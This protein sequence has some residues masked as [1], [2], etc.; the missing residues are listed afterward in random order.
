MESQPRD[1]SDEIFRGKRPIRGLPSMQQNPC[2]NEDNGAGACEDPSSD[3][4][5]EFEGEIHKSF[6]FGASE[7]SDSEGESGTLPEL[8]QEPEPDQVLSGTERTYLRLLNQGRRDPPIAD[9][10]EEEDRK[11]YPSFFRTFEH[12]YRDGIL[13]FKDRSKE[14]SFM[15][16]RRGE[17][18]WAG[19]DLEDRE[20][21]RF[22]TPHLAKS[23]FQDQ[24]RSWSFVPTSE[25]DKNYRGA[26]AKG[27]SHRLLQVIERKPNDQE[28][29]WKTWHTECDGLERELNKRG[30]KDVLDRFHGY[31][32]HL[33]I[34]PR[35]R[36]F[37]AGSLKGAF[38][39]ARPSRDDWI[40]G[41][42]TR[43][44]D[45]TSSGGSE[46]EQVGGKKDGD[47][48]EWVTAPWKVKEGRERRSE[49]AKLF[50][51]KKR[52]E[53]ERGRGKKEQVRP[54]DFSS[55]ESDEPEGPEGPPEVE[56]EKIPDDPPPLEDKESAKSFF[57]ALA[58]VSPTPGACSCCADQLEPG[59]F[60]RPNAGEEGDSDG[61]GDEDAVQSS[62]FVFLEDGRGPFL[63]GDPCT[64]PLKEGDRVLYDLCEQEKGHLSA[65][66]SILFE[67]IE[68]G[69]HLPIS[70]LADDR[71]MICEIDELPPWVSESPTFDTKINLGHRSVEIKR[72]VPGKLGHFK[73]TTALAGKIMTS[74]NRVLSFL[75]N[76]KD[77]KWKR[78]IA[79][80]VCEMCKRREDEGKKVIRA[81][82]SKLTRLRRN[83]KDRVPAWWGNRGA[84]WSLVSLWALHGSFKKGEA[85][86]ES[87]VDELAEFARG[88][89]SPAQRGGGEV[90]EGERGGEDVRTPSPEP[91][92]KKF[93]PFLY[94][95]L[96]ASEK[97][98]LSHYLGK[99]GICHICFLEEKVGASLD[100][101]MRACD[102]DQHNKKMHS[103]NGNTK[104][105]DALID[106]LG[107]W[108]KDKTNGSKRLPPILNPARGFYPDKVVRYGDGGFF[109]PLKLQER[110][111]QSGRGVFIRKSAIVK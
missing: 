106:G 69:I 2:E 86:E 65:Y 70:G 67:S 35:I 54:R 94:A 13:W 51:A 78:A 98:G 92:R 18:D 88:E 100:G 102:A 99:A 110:F 62:D 22:T 16:Y 19:D 15:F 27:F 66:A 108:V 44:E 71:G 8:K 42:A 4:D 63:S 89:E 97:T 76:C 82:L 23:F 34:F 31:E 3:S 45:H 25:I 72:K 73:R 9:S 74:R 28:L 50:I 32:D 59:L 38:I 80:R 7:D 46:S 107:V 48:Q 57:D 37:I 14:D 10:K 29:H 33:S 52:R 40:W 109:P 30:R 58:S 47:P 95:L 6:V 103:T 1:T 104:R 41:R 60:L 85:P 90:S 79:A 87:D 105:A 12:E 75:Y 101:V 111:T 61:V 21:G 11:R 5:G 83:V 36:N 24:F 53:L 84:V 93:K 39:S 17:D 49:R 26:I 43:G 20:A 68:P 55:V 64:V 56:E 77:P 91:S 81:R 96:L